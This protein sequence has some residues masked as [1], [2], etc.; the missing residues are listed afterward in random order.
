METTDEGR[1]RD[2]TS[3]KTVRTNVSIPQGDEAIAGDPPDIWGRPEGMSCAASG[4]STV[5]GGS[6]DAGNCLDEGCVRES[7]P[8]AEVV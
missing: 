6:G 7:A 2:R 8:E 5:G 1:K 3:V 4:R